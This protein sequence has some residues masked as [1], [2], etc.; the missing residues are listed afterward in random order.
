MKSVPHILLLVAT[1]LSLVACT[2]E[3]PVV[4]GTDGATLMTKDRIGST[5][6]ISDGD[7]T[8]HAG[9][10]GCEPT[11]PPPGDDPSISDDGDDISDSEKSRKKRR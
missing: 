7:N 4:P 11:D 8:P 10:T 2:K 1:A 3:E 5:T 6:G 9:V